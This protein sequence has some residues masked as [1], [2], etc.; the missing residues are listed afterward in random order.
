MKENKGYEK[1][2]IISHEAWYAK[3]PVNSS[4]PLHI[5][6]GFY[7]PEGTMGEF[8]INWEKNGI[9]LKVY[10]DAWEVFSKMPELLQLLS[11]LSRQKYVPGIHEFAVLL[12][13]L[14]FKD[15]TKRNE[16]EHDENNTANK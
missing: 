14:G 7:C 12:E 11:R 5:M 15:I 1:A 10:D 13:K 6:V 8:S 2:F 9:L 16:L 4:E 3:S